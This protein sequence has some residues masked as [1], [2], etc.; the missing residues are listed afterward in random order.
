MGG[1]LTMEYWKQK[2]F[3]Q[4]DQPNGEMILL[5]PL[6][7]PYAWFGMRW[8]F[9]LAK[10]TVA[11]RPRDVS[12]NIDNPDFVAL[13][14]Q[15]PLQAR[16]LPVAWV[17]AMVN[18]FRRF[19]SSRPS[20][21]KPVI[22]HGYEDRTVSYRHNLP[23]LARVYPQS[24]LHIVPPAR[25]HLVNETPDIQAAIWERLDAVCDWTSPRGETHAV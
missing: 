16:T 24:Q 23:V 12:T 6:I 9:E 7:R 11:S 15:D 13:L 18:W 19:E 3:A 10:R 20:A 14:S 25:H 1:A 5:A 17:D 2:R 21:L 4:N 8:V 22:V